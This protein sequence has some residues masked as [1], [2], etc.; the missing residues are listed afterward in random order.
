[1]KNKFN[2]Y[3]NPYL[4]QLLHSVGL[5]KNFVKGIDNH[6]W[7]SDG[8]QYLDFISGYGSLPFGHNNK[9]LLSIL[10]DIKNE[11]TPNICQPSILGPASDLAEQL[12]KLTPPSLKFVTFTNS[13]TEAVE[14]AI[15]ACRAVSGK[16]GILSTVNGFHGKTMG[17]LCATGREEYQHCFGLP[18]DEFQ[19][20]PFG[21]TTALE[22]Y[23]IKNAHK[24]AAFIVEPIQGE[25]GMVVPPKYY[26]TRVSELC[27]QYDVLFILD[28]IQTGLG[29]TGYFL[30]ADKEGVS[31]DC[32]LLAKALGGGLTPIGAC[33]LSSKA[34]SENFALKH[35]STFAGN[36][37]SCKIALA[38]LK[39][40]TDKS[41]DNLIQN[42][43]LN[44]KF[45]RYKLEKIA[46]KYPAVIKSVRG[47]GLM[48]GIEID[49]TLKDYP[50]N[51]GTFIGILAEQKLLI[52][53]IVGYLLNK[54]KI[55]VAP[56]LNGQKT[57]RIEPA[58]IITKEQ[59]NQFIDAFTETISVI[60]SGNS[61]RLLS[62]FY[63]SKDIPTIYGLENI[64]KR[65]IVLPDN[66]GKEHTFA[67]LIH[68]LEWK[69][70][71][72]W[73]ESFTPFTETDIQILEDKLNGLIEPV[74]ISSTRITSKTGVTAYG[75]FII[76]PYSTNS[77]LKM[78][79]SQSLKVIKSGVAL[80]KKRGAKIVGL[81]AYTSVLTQG[82][83]KVTNEGV[84]V[85]T[86]NSYTVVS[87]IEAT[88]DACKKLGKNLS[89]L[90]VSIIGAS[91]SIGSATARLLVGKVNQLTL[92]GNPKNIKKTKKRIIDVVE[93]I[94]QHLIEEKTN[95]T[96]TT[97]NCVSNRI[98]K[99]KYFPKEVNTSET[100]LF[101][102]H[103]VESNGTEI[104]LYWSVDTEK[105]L[106]HSDIVIVA[107]SST[108][109]I[110]EIADFKNNAVICS[111]SRPANISPE[112]NIKRPDIMYIDGGVVEVP[113][114][115]DLNCKFGFD[116]GYSFA[117]MAE[118]MMLSLEGYFKNTSIGINLD[119]NIIN[120]LQ[121]LANKHGFKL[122][123]LRSND[124]QITKE[125]WQ[126]VLTNQKMGQSKF[127]K[128]LILPENNKFKNQP[129]NI[130]ELLVKRNI[131]QGRQDKIAIIDGDKKCTYSELQN[132]V[133]YFVK[134]L[135]QNK[136]K[137]HDFVAIIS[138]D[139]IES[140]AAWISV[141]YL[142]GVST[143]LNSFLSDQEYQDHF[144][145]Y[146]SKFIF[147]DSKLKPQLLGI[148]KNHNINHLDINKDIFDI[149][150]K[151]L[152]ISG[153]D[154]ILPAN[155]LESDPAICFF[156]SGSTGK[157]NAVIHTHGDIYNTNINYAKTHLSINEN[158]ITFSHSKS[159][160]AYGFNS[161]HFALFS[162]ATVILAPSKAKADVL[163][164]IIETYK[165]TIFFAVPTVY[166]LMINKANKDYNL[167]C[168][169]VCISAGE[170]LPE[171]IYAVW[172]EKFNIKII[173]GIGTT[174]VLSTFISNK[175]RDLKVASTGKIVPGFDVRLITEDDTE[176]K[177]GEP[178]VLWVKGNTVST[179]YWKNDKAT[180][181][182]FS[183]AW[184]NTN[185]VFYKDA[186]NYYYYVGRKNDMLK[187]G[188]CWLSPLAIEAVV[189]QHSSV[190]E[191]AVVS[192]SELGNL[193]RPK[194]YVVIKDNI[195]FD[196]SLEFDI[197][198][199]SKNRLSLNQYPHKVEF[200]NKLPKTI[201]G[202]IRRLDLREDLFQ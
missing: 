74:V 133:R 113:G 188:G 163:F 169:R 200:V 104:P 28:E 38:S 156:T 1:M 46:E 168:I 135:N 172:K 51:V 90:N 106:P 181:E 182:Y 162:G 33:L 23:F 178:G 69:N 55:R 196:S 30:A 81:G 108:E 193:I 117:C 191:C 187:V 174:E 131:Q 53:V 71:A 155:T 36:S 6:L 159:F 192:Y 186:Q 99:H 79:K 42:T 158:D 157:P 107:T 9:K 146:N 63:Q 120:F 125:Q 2:E 45:L 85:T 110:C 76:I 123:D 29:R 5:D 180:K 7:D 58:L 72:E 41:N 152:N 139:S 50:A 140:T 40:I 137:K 94:I 167:T 17:A 12:I 59:C 18:Y 173:D 195:K 170:P 48:L 73:D 27:H 60:S 61:G 112:L 32:L 127:N 15:K 92:V 183:G 153:E 166:L 136:I 8:H 128:E 105:V 43:R 175:E 4:Y 145:K 164:N 57:I 83:R 35:S 68:P 124:R 147:I 13:G 98:L 67:F 75:E 66:S 114:R 102:R 202:K 160:F 177:L 103:I 96:I 171:D 80:A 148:A 70:Y 154:V 111:L 189:K 179:G 100:Q 87:A 197:I 14:A 190:S 165:P 25:G 26:L 82:G 56:T 21:D 142:G 20:I 134:I 97:N 86:G 119:N 54:H 150:N 93:I 161:I 78:P 138:R 129:L 121:K 185:D 65:N 24:T 116:I 19:Y 89:E 184:F 201:T 22:T 49:I 52:P 10:N 95:E 149:S 47:I 3:M 77:L 11:Q 84:P 151:Q 115:P 143:F 39:L 16:L 132:L 64:K 176:A 91:G 199:F 44:G 144:T 88:I 101:A 34:Y 118:T 31:P 194:A 126:N 122:G 141:L 198:N 109:Q 37:I 62:Y 130:T